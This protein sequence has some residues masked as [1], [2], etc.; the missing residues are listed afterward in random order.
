MREALDSV[1]AQTAAVAEIIVVDDGSPVPLRQPENWQGPPLVWLRT[2]NRGLGAARNYGLRHCQGEFVAFLDSDD[3]W[4]AE[5]ISA[6]QRL[7]DSTPEAVACYTH[8]VDAEGFFPFGPYPDPHLAADK[9]AVLLWHGQFFP[10]S[11]VLVRRQAALAA[12]AFREGLVNGED[13]DM[14]FR[15][16]E[17]GEIVGVP[18]PLTW[19]RIH[20]SQ[21]TSDP[22][23]RVLGSKEA[24]R[25]I[26]QHYSARL[27]RGGID[28]RALWDAYRNEI[29]CVYYRRQFAAARPMLGDYW[30]DHPLDLR[31]LAYWMVTWLPSGWILALRGKI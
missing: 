1:A 22:V 11:S 15:L 8:C 30:R 12:G 18:Q 4:E 13:L 3:V 20:E 5:K 24:R 16:L 31:I 7:L 29:L 27:I 19:Y 6:Q 25:G 9:L 10:P 23:R 17:L 28:A 2:E 21:I 26:L 14:W